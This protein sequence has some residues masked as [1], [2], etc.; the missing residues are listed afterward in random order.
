[1]GQYKIEKWK[2]MSWQPNI[3]I[4]TML[5]IRRHGDGPDLNGY[6]QG[7]FDITILDR[8]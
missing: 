4:S 2:S 1:M 7:S 6:G 5:L 8:N 3:L